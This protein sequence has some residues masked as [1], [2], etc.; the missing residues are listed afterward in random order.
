MRM[1]AANIA[2]VGGGGGGGAAAAAAAVAIV[3][4]GGPG[5]CRG[6]GHCRGPHGNNLHNHT[7]TASAAAVAVLLF[8]VCAT[9][10]G[11]KSSGKSR[12]DSNALHRLSLV[13][14]GH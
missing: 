10:A 3:G 2:I 14:H 11:I 6:P 5:R 1:H 9:E 8:I 13:Q 12:R 7:F 4:G